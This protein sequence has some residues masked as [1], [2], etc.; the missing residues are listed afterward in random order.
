[1][2]SWTLQSGTYYQKVSMDQTTQ[3]RVALVVNGGD[4]TVVYSRDFGA[5]WTPST[6]IT[7]NV[8]TISMNP[9]GNIVIVGV[10]SLLSP[11]FISTNYGVSFTGTYPLASYWTVVGVENNNY[12]IACDYSGGTATVYLSSNQGSSWSAIASYGGHL[13]SNAAWSYNDGMMAMYTLRFNTNSPYATTLNRTINRGVSWSSISNISSYNLQDVACDQTG[14]YVVVS[15]AQD[16]V[17]RSTDYGATWNKT[18]L[19]TNAPAGPNYQQIECDWTGNKISVVDSVNKVIYHS[20]NGGLTW[21]IQTTTGSSAGSVL[22]L[23]MSSNGSVQHASFSTVGTYKVSVPEWKDVAFANNQIKH[24]RHTACDS[25]SQHMVAIADGGYSISYSSDYGFTW[26][27]S[28]ANSSGN[29]TYTCMAATPSCQHVVAG[30]QSTTSGIVYSANYGENFAIVSTGLN[31]V[32]SAVAISSDGQT[33]YAA[34]STIAG[35]VYIGTSGGSLIVR[36][37][38]VPSLFWNSIACDSTGQ[39]V[40]ATA[41][42]NGTDA[43]YY[44]YQYNIGT[45]YVYLPLNGSTTDIMGNSTITPTG[46]ITYTTGT[47]SQY[48][49]N[50]ANTPASA[51]SKYIIGTWT[52]SSSFTMSFWFNAQSLGAQQILVGAYNGQFQLILLGNNQLA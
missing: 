7:G 24:L 8:N 21:T 13:I 26:T 6:G 45:P 32:P 20:A 4:D 39:L 17:Y 3:F 48:A 2:A 47:S 29:T 27:L 18:A 41:K 35:S 31:F 25:T 12:M 50:L 51:A 10:N 40:Y 5:T 37:I 28:D 49:V 44:M 43:P 34:T 22:G 14:Q 42:G 16:G 36:N 52:G 15:A 23:S 1:M 33:F 30:F 19:Y 9:N 38:G 11:A 46:S